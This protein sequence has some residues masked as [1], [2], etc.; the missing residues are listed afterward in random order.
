MSQNDCLLQ[1]L[2]LNEFKDFKKFPKLIDAMKECAFGANELKVWFYDLSKES[3][4]FFESFSIILMLLTNL[5]VL[6]FVGIGIK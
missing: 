4:L 6:E 2:G 1:L 3:D 5:E